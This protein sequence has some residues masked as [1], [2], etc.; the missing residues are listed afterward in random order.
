MG[1]E[2]AEVVLAP[3]APGTLLPSDVSAVRLVFGSVS[4][5][6]SDW[7]QCAGFGF[8]SSWH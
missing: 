5:A 8:P 2:V 7:Y 4:T 3:G 6:F 1:L